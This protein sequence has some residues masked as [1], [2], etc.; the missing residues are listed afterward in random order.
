MDDEEGGRGEERQD[1]DTLDDDEEE[2][3]EE[4]D[5]DDQA[6]SRLLATSIADVVAVLAAS[7]R[8][9]RGAAAASETPIEMPMRRAAP[10]AIE[11]L[12]R[13]AVP[14]VPRRPPPPGAH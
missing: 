3:E 13:I 9:A 2:D 11:S 12:L 4:D 14:W 6:R 8:F 10:A 5:D 1:G 7:E